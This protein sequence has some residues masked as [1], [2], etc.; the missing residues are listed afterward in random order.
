MDAGIASNAY[1][2]NL[3]AEIRGSDGNNPVDLP[4]RPPPD[5]PSNID[6]A[7]D[8]GGPFVESQIQIA[9]AGRQLADKVR[10]G[11]KLASNQLGDRSDRT[12]DDIGRQAESEAK[13]IESETEKLLESN[14]LFQERI[15]ND[16]PSEQKKQMTERVSAQE[17]ILTKQADVAIAALSKPEPV[18]EFKPREL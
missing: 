5:G 8:L 10:E 14:K 17:T 18:R 7:N 12:A 11:G 2:A 15:K 3:S 1:E 6:L 13:K 9:E 4:D 16:P